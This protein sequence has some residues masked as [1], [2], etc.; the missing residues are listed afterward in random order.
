MLFYKEH[1]VII[2]LS[3]LF[4]V[5]S[6]TI[7]TVLI[8]IVLANIFSNLNDPEIVKRNIVIFLISIYFSNIIHLCS[9]YLKDLTEAYLNNFITR[10]FVQAVLNKY[11]SEYKP[12][13]VNIVFDKIKLVKKAITDCIY[14]LTTIF[15]PDFIALGLASF[16]LFAVSVKF[17]FVSLIGFA[18]LIAISFS[19]VLPESNINERDEL[20]ETL[21][22]VFVNIEY[23]KSSILG[24]KHAKDDIKIKNDSYTSKTFKFHNKVMKNQIY[25]YMMALF[26]YTICIIYLYK[27]Y[28]N[29]E[30]DTRDFEST[31]LM[32]VQM[33]RLIFNIT[34]NIPEFIGDIQNIRELESYTAK[35]FSYRTKKVDEQ[36]I[37]INKTIIEFKN[38][39]FSFGDNM[40]LEDFST[41]LKDNKMIALYGPSGSGKST[42]VK[43]IIDMYQPEKGEIFL[44]GIP[45]KSIS[46]TNI[47]K[48]ISYTSQNTSSLMKKTIYDNIVFGIDDTKEN[49]KRKVSDIVRN[50]DLYKIFHV[51]NFLDM[52]V[53]KVG[54]SLSGGQKQ[55]IHLI[56]SLLNKNSK[57]IVLDEPTSALDYKTRKR[58]FKLI[59]GAK[60]EGK[61]IIVIT[62]DK[63]LRD[64]CDVVINFNKNGNPIIK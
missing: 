47:R 10:E 26:L 37:N 36:N 35:L 5:I 2:T 30:V 41:T 50:Y 28:K 39:S 46:K 7:N 53:Q 57:I 61:M 16:R 51:E 24:E 34:E 13:E 6:K 38:V 49:L 58:V 52:K 31:L 18:G 27:L 17:G 64:I 4:V 40:I 25:I 42:F 1:P 21:E 9:I 44:D 55:V 20:S 8:P 54:S 11:D 56:H 23:I 12:I 43:L 33:F 3:V 62:H 15:L 45:L 63:D 14:Y 19:L 59:K 48:Y 60:D 32:L 22:D 29:E